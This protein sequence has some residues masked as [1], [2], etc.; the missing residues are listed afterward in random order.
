MGF[1]RRT[2][3]SDCYG[4]L[5]ETRSFTDPE[6]AHY[7]PSLKRS[8]SAGESNMVRI[9]TEPM[10]FQNAAVHPLSNP[11]LGILLVEHLPSYRLIFLAARLFGS[12]KF[13]RICLTMVSRLN[14]S[15]T[16]LAHHN[17]GGKSW[18][19]ALALSPSSY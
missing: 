8:A 15:A 13:I 3:F 11:R 2:A 5:Q 4:Y 7:H 10:R 14:F 6:T 1:R 19:T 18:L 9:F 12:S 17:L 16:T